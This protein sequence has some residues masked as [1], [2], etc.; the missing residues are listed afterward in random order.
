MKVGTDAQEMIEP[1]FD[2]NELYDIDNM[3][4]KEKRE[5]LDDASVRLNENSKIHMR[6]KSIMVWL[7]YIITK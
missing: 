1:E 6:L 3:S 5:N 2:E 4:L 7:V